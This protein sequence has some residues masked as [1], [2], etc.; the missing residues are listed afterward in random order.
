M[1]RIIRQIIYGIFYLALFAGIGYGGYLLVG[2]LTPSCFDNRL[3]Q[4][5]EQ[6]DCG[7]PCVSCALKNLQ[8]LRTQ[9]QTFGTD[10][11]TSVLITLTNPNLTHGARVFTYKMNFYDAS[12][13]PIFSLAKESFIYPAEAQKFILEPNLKVNF[14]DIS[15]EP[16]FVL[17][18]LDWRP[19]E[20]FSEPKTQIRQTK[21]EISGRQITVSGLL[22][23]RDPFAL[24]RASV[25]VLLYKNL[26]EERSE[27]VGISKTVLQD[28]KPFEERAFKIIVPVQENLKLSD[29]DTIITT[30]ALR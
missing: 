23:N 26:P 1:S 4:R 3:N 21:T 15:G 8:P 5:E 12:K 25:G 20:E 6:I 27:L 17:E 30:E 29:I 13:K 24:S 9:I 14:S 28:L 2:G 11:S 16:E 19:I 10:G 22:S 7:G 18:N